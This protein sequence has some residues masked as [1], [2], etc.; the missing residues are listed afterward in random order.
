MSAPGDP[1]RVSP[2]RIFVGDLSASA[3]T[4]R[5]APALVI[6]SVGLGAVF[7]VNF[8]VSEFDRRSRNLCLGHHPIQSCPPHP[9]VGLIGFIYFLVSVFEIG[10][11]GTQRVWFVRA[12][13][14]QRMNR[15]EVWRATW[16]FF[17]RYFALVLFS[18]PVVIL[19]LA[20]SLH[21]VGRYRIMLYLGIF[22]I[23]V[24][25]T[26]VTPALA[27][28]TRRLRIAIPTGFRMLRSSWPQSAWYALAPPLTILFISFDF[29]R[30]SAG[31]AAAV[32]ISGLVVPI[33]HLW[34]RSATAF[35]Y[36]RLVPAVGPDGAAF[37]ARKPC[38]NGHEVDKLALYCPECGVD[39]RMP[40]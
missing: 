2:W 3:Q 21:H 33:L 24:L 28:S 7:A 13:Q 31:I 20:L 27:F 40:A 29:V 4:L 10:F 5:S 6:L 22:L 15:S 1:D 36:L 14:G 25:A 30:R 11:A 16:S 39:V 12:S 8:A 37:L 35:F 23:E 18:F 26:F 9:W 32:V 38:R 19:L 34:A 17:G